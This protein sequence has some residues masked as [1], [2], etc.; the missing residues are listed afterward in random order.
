MRIR[1][2]TDLGAYVR[3]RRNELGMD[4]AELAK[5]AGT[6]RKWLVEVERGKPG[7]EIGLVLQTLRALGVV[8]DLTDGRRKPDE[9]HRSRDISP[10]ESEK[11][12]ESLDDVLLPYEKTRIKWSNLEALSKPRKAKREKLQP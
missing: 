7:A 3:S 4:Q 1:T 10:D 11:E 8:I 2:I 9:T 12:T 5:K 6:S